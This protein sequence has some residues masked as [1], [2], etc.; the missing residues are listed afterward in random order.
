MSLAGRFQR[1]HRMCWRR[2]SNEKSRQLVHQDFT[3]G[4]PRNLFI[5]RG[6][7]QPKRRKSG[8]EHKICEY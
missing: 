8:H 7:I 5:L 1:F 6:Q 2:S 4:F 3:D